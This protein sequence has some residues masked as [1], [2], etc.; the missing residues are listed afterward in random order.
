[1]KKVFGDYEA[2][3]V[4]GKGSFGTVYLATQRSTQRL[5]ALK[6]VPEANLSERVKAR[7]DMEINCQQ[8]IQS[9]YVVALLDSFTLRSGQYIALEYCEGGDLDKFLKKNGPVSE[10]IAQKWMQQLACGLKELKS[11]KIMHRDLKLQNILLTA[12]ST[13]AAVKLAD[14]GMSKVM[15]E[16]LTTTRLGSPIYMA[17]EMFVPEAKYDLK[18]DVWSLGIVF[19]QMV[20]GEL[21]LEAKFKAEIP[22]AQRSL[23]PVPVELSECCKDLITRML[24]YES[25]QRISFDELFTHPFICPPAGQQPAESPVE[26]AQSSNSGSFDLV[27][28]EIEEQQSE[29]ESPLTRSQTDI[30][31]VVK[32]MER[33]LVQAE[34][35]GK[36]ISCVE[37]TKEVLGLF[38]L[39]VKRTEMLKLA[40]EKAESES[41]N[42]SEP[43]HPSFHAAK[44]KLW[45]A[46]LDSLA[47]SEACELELTSY[48]HRKGLPAS[49]TLPSL[50]PQTMADCLVSRYGWQLLSEASVD[51][52][53]QDY[54]SSAN[55]YSLALALL[56]LV[57]EEPP[58]GRKR[59]E[60]VQIEA[61]LT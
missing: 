2:F 12:E 18:A 19:Y 36:V 48:I 45:Q 52:C 27:D 5:V 1:M 16:D 50:S 34:M 6:E 51:E 25:T 17:P 49:T 38:A 44:A 55:S 4:L 7:L 20:T 24:A 10:S 40:L 58:E 28:E 57:G 3:R 9:Q 42:Y 14:F 30:E 61:K 29:G 31:A 26:L 22:M 41:E 33:E 39:T 46:F 15:D 56:E 47:A 54:T 53:V 35:V 8:A 59:L 21:P 11:K 23:K 60:A 13:S 43:L 32:S 37:T